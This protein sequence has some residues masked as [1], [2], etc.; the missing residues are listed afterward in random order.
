MTETPA[1]QTTIVVPPKPSPTADLERD[2]QNAINYLDKFTQSGRLDPEL[3]MAMNDIQNTLKTL[4][5]TVH[6]MSSEATQNHER[7]VE[8]TRA[9][10]LI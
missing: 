7:M 10:R 8:M 9:Q 4:K 6:R 1:S 3:R 5:Q 2:A